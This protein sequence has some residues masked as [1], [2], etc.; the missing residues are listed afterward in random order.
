VEDSY[1]A[2][3]AFKAITRLPRANIVFAALVSALSSCYLLTQG[4][5]EALAE[6]A[7]GN[8]RVMM[9]LASECLAIGI[10][11]KTSQLDENTFFELF[12]TAKPQNPRRKSGDVTLFLQ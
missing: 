11:K 1:P 12:P 8:P 5:A 2:Y 3:A 9:N 10:R 7:A 4:L 6:H